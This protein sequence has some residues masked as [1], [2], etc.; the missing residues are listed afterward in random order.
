MKKVL[1]IILIAALILMQMTMIISATNSIVVTIGMVEA[2][3][4]STID[5]Y[6]SLSNADSVKT[7]GLNEFQ[8]DENHLL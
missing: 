4:N 5:V 1:S 7:I 8:Y 3:A 2:E 6:V